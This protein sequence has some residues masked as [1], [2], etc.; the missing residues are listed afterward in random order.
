LGHC[1]V[2]WTIRAEYWME[3][4]TR[5]GISANVSLMSQYTPQPHVNNGPRSIRRLTKLGV[6]TRFIVCALDWSITPF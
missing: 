1:T 5:F 4:L 6:R 2:A 3:L